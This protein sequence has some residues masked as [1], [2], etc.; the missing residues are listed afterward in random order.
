M[1]VGRN[2]WLFVC[3][4]LLLVA[5]MEF[6]LGVVLSR[7]DQSLT[8]PSLAV[9]AGGLAAT[10]VG[11]RVGAVLERRQLHMRPGVRPL[12]AGGVVIAVVGFLW[13]APG[14]LQ[15]V[16]WAVG[17][18]VLAVEVVAFILLRTAGSHLP[19]RPSLRQSVAIL[20]GSGLL[21]CLTASFGD[22][23]GGLS[24]QF[25]LQ[26]EARMNQLL[27]LAM[28]TI[29]QGPPDN[30]CLPGKDFPLAPGLGPLSQVCS[31]SGSASFQAA[32]GQDAYYEWQASG[33]PGGC[34]VHLDGPWWD[35]NEDSP[36]GFIC[37]GSG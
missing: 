14:F 1:P 20:V 13:V 26:D 12:A 23:S 10:L 37:V 2:G 21:T 22:S 25:R 27:H 35:D 18:V 19:S 15:G 11:S 34:F 4:W 9:F 32:D 31:S 6:A 5:V 8:G 17:G 36:G 30:G 33:T 28:T 24:V 16:A 29:R 7:M 3:G